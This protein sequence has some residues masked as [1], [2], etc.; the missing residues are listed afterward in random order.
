MADKFLKYYSVKG[1][2]KRWSDHGPDLLMTR[3]DARRKLR[4]KIR[5]KSGPFFYKIGNRDFIKVETR[6]EVLDAFD[7]WR[8][9]EYFKVASGTKDSVV[10]TV[11]R[12]RVPFLELANCSPE[13]SVVHSLI[14]FRF[15][16]IKFA[17]GYVWKETSPGVWSDHAWGTAVDE[18]ENPS[19]GVL[20]DDVTD[21]VA[22][23]RRAGFMQFDYALGSRRGDVVI[24]RSDG[25]ISPSSASDSHLWHVHVS[26]VDHDGRKP[27]REGGVW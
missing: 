21:W 17:G 11:R 14:Q 15:P 5:E 19:A 7:S 26:V 10:M 20:N 2:T 18:T 4:D 22:R 23:M 12:Y 6:A 3:P 13:T 9:E 16:G 25:S 27:P 24:V 8:S 1:P